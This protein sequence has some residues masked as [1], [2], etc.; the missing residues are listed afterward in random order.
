V[1]HEIERVEDIAWQEQQ[2]ER[3][4]ENQEGRRRRVELG[5][6]VTPGSTR[7]ADTEVSGGS[8]LADV[9]GPGRQIQ[10]NENVGILGSLLLPPLLKTICSCCR[11]KHYGSALHLVLPQL[12]YS[13]IRTE[14]GCRAILIREVNGQGVNGYTGASYVSI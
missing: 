13:P 9:E 7:L 2:W 11:L 1:P 8:D 3:Q 12:L 5:R 14:I 6:P 4:D 10:L